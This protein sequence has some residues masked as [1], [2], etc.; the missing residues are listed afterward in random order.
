MTPTVAQL[1]VADDGRSRVRQLLTGRGIHGP[2]R[3]GN[4]ARIGAGC[5]LFPCV[6]IGDGALLEPGAVAFRD[7]PAGSILRAP[8]PLEN[9]EAGEQPSL[10]RFAEHGDERGKLRVLDLQR[11]AG[12]AARRTFAITG[13]PEDAVRAQHAHARDTQVLQIL[14]GEIEVLLCRPNAPARIA[15]LD[16]G[17]GLRLP[18]LTW[19]AMFGF[20]ANAVVVVHASQAFDP[21]DVLELEQ[22]EGWANPRQTP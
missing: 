16:A 2:A 19:C 21:G 10:L 5:V 12:F 8:L 18:P 17:T 3:I 11:H 14:V 13:V 6:H 20:S 22:L 9:S 1:R 15:R 4:G 7:V